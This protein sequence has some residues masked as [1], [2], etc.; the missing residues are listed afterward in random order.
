MLSRLE[1]TTPP[2]TASAYMLVVGIGLGL[3]M[4]VVVLVVQNDAPP[5]H[6]GA[7]TSTATFFRSMGGSMGVALFGAIFASRLT[8]ELAVL[9]GAAKAHLTGGIHI[10]PEQVR[11]LPP[12]LQLGFMQAFV[13]A[14]QPVFLAG[15]GVTAATFVLALLL[16]EVPLRT[17][18]H[19]EGDML[20]EESIVGA[21]GVE[22]LIG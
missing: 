8:S 11:A 1:A 3:V 12:Q 13:E 10:S 20:A 19:A 16:K 18:V 22:E 14:L 21:T 17:R 15:A 5:E 7:A 6:V 2:I 4:Q 9:P